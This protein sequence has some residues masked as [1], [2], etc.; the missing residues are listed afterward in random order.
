V[1]FHGFVPDAER[2][3]LLSEAHCFALLSAGEGL[4]MAVLEALACGTPAVVSEGCHLPEIDEVG[5]IETDGS[6]EATA[7]AL[8]RLLG[9][10]ALRRRLSDGAREFAA[11]FR[12]D[13]VLPR[14]EAELQ[15]IARRTT[16]Q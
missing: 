1:A 15:R 14:L 10:E 13:A 2:L 5:G 9:D 16:D 12:A 6:A 4:P 8:V 7:A 3:R 11:A